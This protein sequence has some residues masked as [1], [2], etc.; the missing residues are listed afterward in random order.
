MASA[1]QE[2]CLLFAASDL[3]IFAKLAELGPADGPQLAHALG[4]SERGARL[5]LDACAAVG[6]LQKE[7][8]RY[9][10]A[11]DAAAFLVPGRPGDLSGALRYNRDVYPAWGKVAEL[12]RTGTPVENPELHLGENP[13]RTRSFVLSS[14]GKAMAMVPM[15]LPLLNVADRSQLLDVGGGP[16]TFSVAIATA[17]PKIKCMVLDLPAVVAIASELIAQKG[18]TERVTLLPGD[19]HTTPFPSGNDVVLLFGMLH[20]E[21]IET[22]RDLL[23]RAYAAMLPGGLLYVM[24]MM[25]DQSHINPPFSAMFAVNMA[26]TKEHGW[27]FS[28]AELKQWVTV[29]GFRDFSVRPLPPPMPHWLASAKK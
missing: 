18:H 25:T 7:N 4:L 5:V 23:A 21:S 9:R 2:S 3:G 8:G 16:G 19:Y 14:H 10:N 12:A 28:D 27:V 13:A 1:F 11:P 20:Q 26:L 29:A 15:V 22:I 24:D 6:L 17:N